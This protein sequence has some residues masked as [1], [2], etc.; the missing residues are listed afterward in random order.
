M[1]GDSWH[2]DED[3]LDE[4]QLD[5]LRGAPDESSFIVTG[6]A[7][8]GKTNLAIW[9]AQDIQSN[10]KGSF[11]LIVY[12]KALRIFIED[13]IKNAEINR[14]RVMHYKLWKRRDMPSADYI[15]VDEAQDFTNAEINEFKSKAN[16]ALIL[17]GDKN[18]QI[19]KGFGNR[20]DIVDLHVLISNNADFPYHF[21]LMLNHRLPK[22]IAEIAELLLENGDD[23][24]L[25]RY[26][27]DEGGDKPILREFNNPKE[28]YDY[29]INKIETE[30]LTHVGILL[31]FRKNIN[32]VY[33]YF[34]N[35]NQNVQARINDYEA[36]DI[37]LADLEFNSPIVPKIITYHSS[38][39]LQFQHVFLPDCSL[40]FD[41]FK[42][43]LY[44][45]MTRSCETLLISYSNYLSPYI[46]SIRNLLDESD[47]MHSGNISRDDS[48]S[49]YS[50]YD[51]PF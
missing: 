23:N 19:Y 18:Q 34:R 35:K 37:E 22:K 38:K 44:V 32:E 43:S 16:T 24:P 3:Q 8:S 49:N 12:T 36:G 7:G 14:D 11:L 5:V 39:G 33:E 42:P 13:G 4:Y 45:S 27:T 9:K 28:Q 6:C 25:S 47:D 15:I 31:P 41:K 2:I 51:L 21:D 26:C 17:Y 40:S 10:N 50:D 29:I 20:E 46:E 48:S 30:Q 1:S